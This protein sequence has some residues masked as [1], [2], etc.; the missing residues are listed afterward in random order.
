MKHIFLTS[1][2][3]SPHGPKTFRL[4]AAPQVKQVIILQL[5][6]GRRCRIP[7]PTVGKVVPFRSSIN[8]TLG[9]AG[10]ENGP[11]VLAFPFVIH[12]CFPWEGFEGERV[13]TPH[14]QLLQNLYYCHLTVEGVE[15]DSV[16]LEDGERKVV[17]LWV[18]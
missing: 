3:L 8:V 7:P 17:L 15:M 12:R 1:Q 13:F 16:D 14:A 6:E 9:T 10:P 18:K 4:K 11:D 5:P 2:L